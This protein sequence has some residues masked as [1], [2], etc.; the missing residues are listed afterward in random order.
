MIVTGHTAM[1]NPTK[2]ELPPIHVEKGSLRRQLTMFLHHDQKIHFLDNYITYCNS[3][4]NMA[5]SQGKHKVEAYFVAC[6][7]AA[8]DIMAGEIKKNEEAK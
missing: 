1:G 8:R 5:I 6:K 7:Q 2:V 3:K 4:M